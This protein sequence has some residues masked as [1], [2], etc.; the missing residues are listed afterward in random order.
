MK[1]FKKANNTNRTYLWATAE[2]PENRNPANNNL[3]IH[4]AVR[5]ISDR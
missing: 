5:F 2:M 1:L 4:P 3:A